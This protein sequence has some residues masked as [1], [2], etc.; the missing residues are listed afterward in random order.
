MKADNVLVERSGVC[1]ISDF[2]ISKRLEDIE[3]R[4]HTM[5]KGTLFWMAPEVIQ[6]KN[7]YGSKV[8]IWSVGCITLEMWSG[9]R[10]WHGMDF[11][12]AMFQVSGNEDLPISFSLANHTVQLG[13]NRQAPPVPADV[14]L[15]SPAEDFRRLCF[16]A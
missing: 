6:A 16:A 13:M 12:F 11:P 5:L 2:G 8:D 9:V 15:P 1:K 10:P 3:T 4:A 14:S 7:G